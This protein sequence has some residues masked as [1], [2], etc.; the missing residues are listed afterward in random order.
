M[1]GGLLT[2]NVRERCINPQ[3]NTLLVGKEE[4]ELGLKWWGVLQGDMDIQDGNGRHVRP[5]DMGF[6][7]TCVKTGRI[8]E[9]K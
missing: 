3:S 2:G 4:A 6:G 7:T 8:R 9:S 1:A 5:G